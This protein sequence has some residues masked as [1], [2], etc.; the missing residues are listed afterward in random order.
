MVQRLTNPTSIH[1]D[2]GSIPG[3][4]LKTVAAFPEMF[5]ASLRSVTLEWT[6]VARPLMSASA[7]PSMAK[8]LDISK[9]ASK[10]GLSPP[11]PGITPRNP[12]VVSNVALSLKRE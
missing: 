1:K 11:P 7:L 6:H 4:V 9:R 10:T 2:A 5:L 12:L 3:P 8:G